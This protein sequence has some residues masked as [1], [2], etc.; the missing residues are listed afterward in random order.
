MIGTLYPNVLTNRFCIS[1]IYHQIKLSIS[2]KT[3]P[4]KTHDK[5]LLKSLLY[6][7]FIRNLHGLLFRFICYGM[8]VCVGLYEVAASSIIL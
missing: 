2:S 8:L 6:L 5:K 1:E 4:N 3:T 7:S